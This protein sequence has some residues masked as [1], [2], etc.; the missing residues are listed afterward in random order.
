MNLLNWYIIQNVGIMDFYKEQLT[1]L[2]DRL[3]RLKVQS[4]PIYNEAEKGI[5]I[6][7]EILDTLRFKVLEEGFENPEMECLFFKTIKPQ[8]VGYIIHYMNLVYLERH[9]P[10]CNG[11]EQSDF[12]VGQISELRNYFTEHREFYE[13]Y[14]RGLTYR[15]VEFFSRQTINTELDLTSIMAVMDM[16]FSTTHDMI[17]A[18]ILGNIRTIEYLQVK[19]EKGLEENPIVEEL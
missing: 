4:L 11:K 6:C 10:Y 2:E 19:I 9:K 13:Y 5:E 14:V 1:L 12:W 15:D 18:N 8:V 3:G 17:L 7:K 16:D